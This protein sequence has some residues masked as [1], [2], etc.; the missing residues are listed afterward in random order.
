LSASATGSSSNNDRRRFLKFLG[1]G[2]TGAYAAG[3]GPLAAADG[4][5]P[6][7]LPFDPIRPT[8]R[9]DLILPEGFS[10]DVLAEWGDVLPGTNARFGYNADFTAFIPLPGNREGVLF[11]N[12]EYVSLPA[13]GEFGVYLQTFPL[14]MGRPATIAEEMHDVG[15]S[16]LHLRQS[17]AGR[18]QVIPSPLTR[19]YDARSR[20]VASG[21][22]LQNTRNVG[23]TLANCSGC[24]TPW[25]TV[26]TCEENFQ[27]C[28]LAPVDT[29]GRGSVGGRFRQNGS[30]FGWVVEI[31]PLDPAWTPVKHTMLGRFRHENVA[32]RMD[33][34]GHAVAYMGDDIV[35]GHVY[36]FISD[37]RYVADGAENR[38]R[39]LSNGRLFAAVFNPDGTGEWRAL[40]GRTPLRPN[41]Q[42]AHPPIPRRAT[43][44]G[45]VYA[46]PGAIVTDAFH[47]SNLIGA[48]PTGRPEDIEVHPIDQSVYI[49]FTGAATSPGHLFPNLYGE[50]W[51]IEDENEG[52]GTRFTWM[53]WKAGGP[54]DPGRRGR[55]FAAPDNLSFEPGGHLW[56][57][58]DI[59][60]SRLN[61]DERYTTFEN[62]GMFFVPAS[63]TDA[64]VAL[65]FASA[66][67]EA[68]L[69]G[70]SWTLDRQTMF[71]SIQ[72]P[73]EASGMRTAGMT[74]P[75]GSNWPRGRA[76]Q[77]P[78]PAVVSIRPT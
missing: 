74:P 47:A 64:G 63:G 36:K 58:T 3:L 29:A 42:S 75:R 20:M 4:P 77:P 35:N 8:T 9:D 68:E 59:T 12:H 13:P 34:S 31:D 39:L 49:A 16:V 6:S 25:N 56:V 66:P 55:V 73:G 15:V 62:N 52:A 71:L 51:R 44:L 1:A 53:R 24:H 18:W 50:I 27:D 46:N 40:A 33:A 69:A 23:G 78:R 5:P 43:T 41:P 72:H 21:P 54:N 11:V 38:G 61:A 10:Y 14:V 28:V 48:T 60:T 67:C 30:H 65:Q 7:F 2:L 57:V 17:E 19:R 22:A 45:Q 32:I 26:L 70:P 37:R 76:D